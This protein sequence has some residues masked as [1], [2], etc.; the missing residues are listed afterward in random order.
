[1]EVFANSLSSWVWFHEVP[2][3]ILAFFLIADP[4]GTLILMERWYPAFIAFL[5]VGCTLMLYHALIGFG[6]SPRKA[7]G[8][9]AIHLAPLILL[10]SPAIAG[11]LEVSLVTYAPVVI[12]FLVCAWVFNRVRL[13]DFMTWGMVGL[14]LGHELFEA[15]I[16]HY[17]GW[18]F[19]LGVDPPLR[20]EHVFALF[21][22]L[23]VLGAV[24]IW[25]EARRR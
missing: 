3:L 19:F 2:E 23:Q 1:M 4:T 7:V 9:T 8:G 17:L 10:L 12:S 15:L 5:L 18:A 20:M 22:I 6:L 13:G 16:L 14:C 25:I 11:P 24:L 21:V